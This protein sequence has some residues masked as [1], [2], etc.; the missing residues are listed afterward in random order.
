MNLVH[1]DHTCGFVCECVSMCAAVCV[2][3]CI[4]ACRQAQQQTVGL[5]G[6]GASKGALAPQAKPRRAAPCLVLVHE[7]PEAAGQRARGDDDL[8]EWVLLGRVGDCGCDN[9]THH[10]MT[11]T[12][13]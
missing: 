1:Q 2:A 12:A 13:S 11:V 5:G 8:Q 3:V 4:C 9:M 10:T 7:R 6:C